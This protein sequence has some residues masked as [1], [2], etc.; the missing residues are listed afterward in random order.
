[1]YDM[2]KVDRVIEYNSIIETRR[3][4]HCHTYINLLDLM[5]EVYN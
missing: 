2:M 3:N 5:L 1:M 4:H